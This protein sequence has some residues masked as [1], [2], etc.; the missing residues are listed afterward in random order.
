MSLQAPE[1][2]PE[3]DV[4]DAL[5]AEPLRRFKN[6]MRGGA[7]A[8]AGEVGAGDEHG[9]GLG[10]IGGIDVFREQAHIGAL[11]A[12][13]DQGEVVV[14]ADAQKD[15]GGEAVRVGLD[16]AHVHA[17]AGKLPFQVTAVVFLAHARD[18]PHAQA[19]AGRADGDVHG[20]AAHGFGEGHGPF[21]RNPE[22]HAVQVHAGAAD[23]DQIKWFW[24]VAISRNA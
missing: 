16:G 4:E 24:H 5:Q 8:L 12:V 22:F 17:F 13:L 21:E 18:R 3:V 14:A 6:F 20:A 7:H 9:L 23:T 10:E 19:E 15:H 1:V 11:F 2:G